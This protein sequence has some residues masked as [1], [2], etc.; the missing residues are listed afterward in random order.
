MDIKI[1]CV[2]LTYTSKHRKTYDV[3]CLLKASGYNNVIVYAVPMKYKKVFKPIYEHRPPVSNA[4]ETKELCKN[5]GYEYIVSYNGYDEV[6]VDNSTPILLCGA[7]ILPDYFIKSHYV[8]NSHPGFIP[9]VRGLD[10]LKWAIV[11]NLPIGVTTHKIGDEVD[12]GEIIERVEIP[13]Y[14]NDTFHALAQR[15]YEKE[16]L[17][18]VNSLNLLGG[19]HLYE[20]GGMNIIHKRMPPSIEQNLLVCFEHLILKKGIEY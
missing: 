7:G 12:A 16:V 11:E 14:K 6:P 3:L 10:A 1:D 9:I 8:I 5:F 2:V 19:N 18:L 20:S 15:V 17:M 4:I 13:V